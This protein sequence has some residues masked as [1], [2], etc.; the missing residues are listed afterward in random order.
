VLRGTAKADEVRFQAATT[1]DGSSRDAATPASAPAPVEMRRERQ[2]EL[3]K[4]AAAQRAVTTLSAADSAAADFGGASVRRIGTR[5]FTLSDGNWTDARHTTT[6][7][8]VRVKPYS[9]AYFALL[10]KLEDLRAPFALM[11]ADGT[12]GVV[13]AGRSVAVAV[14]ADGA[15]T[16]GTRELAAIEAGW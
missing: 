12:P 14:A 7:R 8:T 4:T 9:A 15:E 6:M 16:L 5:T 11:G 3:A 10:E 1:G 2:F 13:V